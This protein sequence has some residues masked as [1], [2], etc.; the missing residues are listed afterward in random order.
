MIYKKLTAPGIRT[1]KN[2]LLI[3]ALIFSFGCHKSNVNEKD[4]RNFQQVNL[5]ANN[6]EYNASNIDSTH[7]VVTKWNCLGKFGGWSRQ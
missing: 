6:G 5:V 2:Y 3:T 4:P 1:G 7:R